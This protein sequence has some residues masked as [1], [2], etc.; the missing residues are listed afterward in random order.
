[1]SLG[2]I[3]GVSWELLENI[4]G[5]LEFPKQD[6]NS[7]M[8]GL[9]HLD[10]NL[11]GGWKSPREG[12]WRTASFLIPGIKFN[13][14]S[15]PPRHQQQPLTTGEWAP[16]LVRNESQ[17]FLWWHSRP[18]A[19]RRSSL[20]WSLSWL[21]LRHSGMLGYQHP[22]FFWASRSSK[23]VIQPPS[24]EHVEQIFL[25]LLAQPQELLAVPP[26][27][28]M[29]EEISKWPYHT[30]YTTVM[31]EH[32]EQVILPSWWSLRVT[33]S[34]FCICFLFTDGVRWLRLT[35]HTITGS[36]ESYKSIPD[37]RLQVPEFTACNTDFWWSSAYHDITQPLNEPKLCP[38]HTIMG[39][40]CY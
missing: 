17:T 27:L 14:T 9:R 16:V 24:T 12:E 19:T 23:H 11:E 2:R 30:N 38:S 3:K 20:V 8:M 35:K 15:Q 22:L 1:M 13:L 5:S 4:S 33:E 21:Q 25:P 39:I 7:E 34:E 36:S 31:H 6:P 40:I 37:P 10:S 18:Q 32:L 29:T 28:H 26:S